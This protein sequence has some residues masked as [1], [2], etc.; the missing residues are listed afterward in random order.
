MSTQ[1]KVILTTSADKC[2]QNNGSYKVVP[3]EEHP[4]DMK[5]Q[6]QQHIP[7]LHMSVDK[8]HSK[9]F[10]QKKLLQN[11]MYFRHLMYFYDRKMKL[12]KLF[13]IKDCVSYWKKKNCCKYQK[14][15]K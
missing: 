3:H 9:D 12:P 11:F 7:H 10:L 2:I 6:T 1:C 14:K 4:N 5:Q 8:Q 13:I 15:N